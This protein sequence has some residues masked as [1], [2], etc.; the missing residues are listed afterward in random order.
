MF[1]LV[2]GQLRCVMNSLSLFVEWERMSKSWGLVP[3]IFNLLKILWHF[4][5]VYFFR[6]ADGRNALLWMRIFSSTLLPLCL[7]DGKE[8]EVLSQRCVYLLCP[9][10]VSFFHYFLVTNMHRLAQLQTLLYI[11]PSLALLFHT[12]NANLYRL[13]PVNL[14]IATSPWPYNQP[15]ALTP[16]LLR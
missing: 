8:N 7:E 2:Q 4:V 15:W 3:T 5:F 13:T 6:T 10:P 1:A 16:V 11:R 12:T 14:E 9:G